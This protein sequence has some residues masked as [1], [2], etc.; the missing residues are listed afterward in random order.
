[1]AT[2]KFSC[3]ICC[4]ESDLQYLFD[5]SLL[6]CIKNIE[7]LNELFVVTP[8]PELAKKVISKTFSA[9]KI[10]IHV[11]RDNEFLSEAENKMCG[12]SK[13]QILKLRSFEICKVENILCVGSD[14]VALEKITLNEFYSAE[15]MIVNYRNHKTENKYLQFELDRVKNIYDLLGIS[16][17]KESET[18][19][20]FIFDIFLF[21]R[22][23]LLELKKY[24]TKKFGADYFLKILPHH[25]NDYNDMGKIGEWSLYTI[26]AIEVLK[27]PFIFQDG[28]ELLHQI[29][30]ET[31]LRNYDYK[32]KA[33]HFVRK[34][35]DKEYIFTELKRRKIF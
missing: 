8:N 17:T 14:T 6:S 20:D 25:V 35:F 33:V 32:N 26:F 28:T 27:Y 23:L 1:M 18:F 13:Q 7:F 4:S 5:L 31:E 34:D 3:V 30:T 16:P 9:C 2:E 19:R 15:N 10:P 24:L 22:S 11:V 12:W 21:N 29:H